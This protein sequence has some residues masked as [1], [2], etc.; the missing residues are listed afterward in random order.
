MIIEHVTGRSL[1]DALRSGVLDRPGLDGLAYRV[2]GALAA[3]GW[4]IE[5]DPA[6]LARWGYELYG[7]FVV[8]DASL[9]QMANS[10]SLEA[11]W[12]SPSTGE[13]ALVYESGIVIK[14]APAQFVDAT[15]SFD[16]AVVGVPNARKTRILGQPALVME[17]DTDPQHDNPG[18]VEF[19]Y[20]D[21]SPTEADGV[22]IVIH[23]D[24]ADGS[25]LSAVA[26]SA[27]IATS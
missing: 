19:V 27:L 15:A 12:L 22:Y 20:E 18:L 26:E 2:K 11:A 14:E 16:A 5:S 13:V 21:R 3:D 6:S 23:G 1:W 8:S 9:G 7:G 25:T 4:R 10:D 24:S 17:P